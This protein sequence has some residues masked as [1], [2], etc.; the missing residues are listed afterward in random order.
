M[1][2]FILIPLFLSLLPLSAAAAPDPAEIESAAKDARRALLE[3]GCHPVDERLL[4]CPEGQVEL[5][6]GRFVFRSTSPIRLED[7]WLAFVS[8]C[9]KAGG[10]TNQSGSSMECQGGDASVRASLSDRELVVEVK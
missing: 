9:L 2:K 6:K 8:E 1:K 4:D 7:V 10:K 3:R 5:D